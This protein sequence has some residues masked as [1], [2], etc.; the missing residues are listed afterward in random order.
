MPRRISNEQIEKIREMQK[1]GFRDSEIARML[2]L[3]HHIVHYQ[4]P[5]VRE[6]YQENYLR[7]RC[8][9]SYEDMMRELYEFTNLTPNARDTV[10]AG[11]L[12]AIGESENGLNYSQILKKLKE[13]GYD[14]KLCEEKNIRWELNR[15]KDLDL[16]RRNRFGKYELT[17]RGR[18]LIK[19]LFPEFEERKQ[20][21]HQTIKLNYYNL[22]DLENQIATFILCKLLYSGNLKYQQLLLR[23]VY[24]FFREDILPYRKFKALLVRRENYLRDQQIKKFRREVLNVLSMLRDLEFIEYRGGRYSLT[25]RGIELAKELCRK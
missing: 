25:E 7:Q 20:K 11:I 14:K 22:P 12:K 5:E 9:D 10:F 3:P 21:H 2:N 1:S 6:R 8:P 19:Q 13:R 23:F 17:D 4:R 15:L 24:T 16:V 18:E